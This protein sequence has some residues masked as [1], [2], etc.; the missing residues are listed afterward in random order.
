[1][2]SSTRSSL[3]DK[4]NLLAT[5]EEITSALDSIADKWT[6]VANLIE[7]SQKQA[8]SMHSSVDAAMTTLVRTTEENHREMQMVQRSHQSTLQSMQ[9]NIESQF[10]PIAQ[11]LTAELCRSG[12]GIAPLGRRSSRERIQ[13]RIQ[14]RTDGFDDSAKTGQIPS[15]LQQTDVARTHKTPFGRL[16]V[17][18]ST[19]SDRHSREKTRTSYFIRFLPYKAFSQTVID[20]KCVIK[21]SRSG[22]LMSMWCNVGRVCDDLDVID[23]LGFITA[24]SCDICTR[25]LRYPGQRICPHTTK[26]PNAS[27]LMR[28]LDQRRFT[29]ADVVEVKKGVTTSILK[30][31]VNNINLRMQQVLT[32][33]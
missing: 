15:Y 17:L 4:F 16:Y 7:T 23:A 14:E 18:V 20:W 3:Q 12:R 11:L 19:D 9:E 10:L 2:H 13:E 30:L 6:A 27:K 1:M 24:N 26:T 29:P 33:D 32:N 31:Y 5:H 22:P 21:T 25:E 8:M 28:L